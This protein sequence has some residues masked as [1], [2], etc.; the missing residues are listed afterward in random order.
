M[1]VEYDKQPKQQILFPRQESKNQ[2]LN[3]FIYTRR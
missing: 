1:V 3:L 2:E